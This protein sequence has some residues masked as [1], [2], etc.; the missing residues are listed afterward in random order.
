MPTHRNGGIFLR[1]SVI[2]LLIPRRIT[3]RVLWLL[4]LLLL[5][6]EHVLEELKLA[7]DAGQAN[8]KE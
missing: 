1:T 6:A 2:L 8:Q 5:S 4:L 7:Q 3:S